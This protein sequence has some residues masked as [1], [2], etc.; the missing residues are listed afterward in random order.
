[1]SIYIALLRAI[2]VGGTGKLA[3][4]DLVALCQRAGFADVRTYIQSGNIILRSPAPAAQVQATLQ[5]AVSQ[6]VKKPIGVFLRTPAELADV[7]AAN[8]FPEAPGSRVIVFFLDAAP[9]REALEQAKGQTSEQLILRGRE[10]YIHYPVGQAE[11][12]L[13]LPLFE[14]GTGRNLN[15]IEKLVELA[16]KSD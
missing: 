13:K 7:L 14:R 1:M 5:Q 4:R 12:R 3:M 2:N 11:S 6:A 16:E 10:L 9:P 8:P 15:T